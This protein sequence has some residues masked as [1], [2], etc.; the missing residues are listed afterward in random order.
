[1]CVSIYIYILK[2]IGVRSYLY[3]ILSL[4]VKKMVLGFALYFSRILFHDFIH[5]MSLFK[6]VKF[7]LLKSKILV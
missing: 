5:G 1:M 7:A 6:K 2:F 4:F 3:V